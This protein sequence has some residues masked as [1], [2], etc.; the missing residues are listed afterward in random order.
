[1]TRRRK[2][3]YPYKLVLV[4][5]SATC[6]K[7]EPNPESEAPVLKFEFSALN[8][9]D[10]PAMAAMMARVAAALGGHNAAPLVS[11]IATTP[12]VVSVRR[13]PG[14]PRKAD[15]VDAYVAAGGVLPVADTPDVAAIVLAEPESTQTVITYPGTLATDLETAEAAFTPEPAMT[16]DELRAAVRT[17]AQDRGALWLRPLLEADKTTKVSGLTEATMRAALAA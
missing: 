5:V 12:D 1:M 10:V 2:S 17:V 9:D 8:A 11:E 15:P 6:Y 14:R 4:S 3:C 16:L 7:V 13:A